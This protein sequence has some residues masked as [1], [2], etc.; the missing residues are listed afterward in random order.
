MVT[1]CSPTSTGPA[2]A[3]GRPR[4]STDDSSTPAAR[5][6]DSATS[7][8]TSPDHYSSPAAS[9]PD[10]TLDCE[11]PDIPHRRPMH[12]TAARYPAGPQK[13][14]AAAGLIRPCPG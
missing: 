4:R 3:T 12:L 7:P 1:T 8:A 5:H 6:P 11:E 9:D 13:P 10:Y 14:H 2:P